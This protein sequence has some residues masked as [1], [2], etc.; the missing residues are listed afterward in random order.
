MQGNLI[1]RA[2]HDLEHDVGVEIVAKPRRHHE[3]KQDVGELFF[4]QAGIE[5][6]GADVGIAMQNGA[7]AR[8]HMCPRFLHAFLA[9]GFF[10]LG[11]T[12]RVQREESGIGC[13]SVAHA[14]KHPANARFDRLKRFVGLVEDLKPDACDRFRYKLRL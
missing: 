11:E 14:L 5:G 12:E 4:G 8:F 1:H 2:A 9:F 13:L 10:G 7:Q 3:R 6:V